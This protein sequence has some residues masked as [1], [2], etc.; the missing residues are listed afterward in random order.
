MAA[1]E[2]RYTPRYNDLERPITATYNVD[3]SNEGFNSG[4]EYSS[5]GEYARDDSKSDTGKNTARFIPINFLYCST[6]I[7]A[8]AARIVEACGRVAAS[9]PND[10]KIKLQT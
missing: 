8:V 5:G 4:D 2:R 7:I 1:D 9:Q 10:L 3:Y 6:A